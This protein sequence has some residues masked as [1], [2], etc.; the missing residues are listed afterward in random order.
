MDSSLLDARSLSHKTKGK[1]KREE[2]NSG[3]KKRM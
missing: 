1:R 2:G 3:E